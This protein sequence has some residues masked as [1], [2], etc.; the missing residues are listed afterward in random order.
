MFGPPGGLYVYF[1]YGMHWCANAVCS[2]EGRGQAVLIRG[3]E[4]LT[5]IAVM[6]ERRSRARRD[7]DL[8]NGPAKLCEALAID[9]GDDGA[10][11]TNA[12]GIRIVDDLR[13]P[14]ARPQVSRRIGISRAREFE[15][16]WS[17]DP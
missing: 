6:R 11:L 1:I 4:P 15:W 16:R 17:V 5:G 12:T 8:C 9:G 14:P 7:A 2:A 10:R 3:L 13:P